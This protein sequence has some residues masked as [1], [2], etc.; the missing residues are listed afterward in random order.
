M[1]NTNIKPDNAGADSTGEFKLIR[2]ST[3][4]ADEMNIE[5]FTV[6]ASDVWETWISNAGAHSYPKTWYIGTNEEIEF[7]S[8]EE[9]EE[10]LTVTDLSATDAAVLLTVFDGSEHVS[11]GHFPDMV[12]EPPDDLV[13]DDDFED[14]DDDDLEDDD[15]E[16]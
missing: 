16:D 11:F 5:G 3:N 13:D 1:I 7:T 4:W 15:G 14:E 6:V 8:F 2:V 12:F 10:C 9:L